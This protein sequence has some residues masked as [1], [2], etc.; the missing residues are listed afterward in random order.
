MLH[1]IVVVQLR[2]AD[3]PN[4][5]TLVQPSPTL[6][7]VAICARTTRLGPII[8]ASPT[9][10]ARCRFSTPGRDR[11]FTSLNVE[12]GAVSCCSTSWCNAPESPAY[13]D[14]SGAPPITCLAPL[15]PRR[16]KLH[17][18][19]LLSLGDL[20]DL[21]RGLPRLYSFV[22]IDPVAISSVAVVVCSRRGVTAER[23]VL[24]CRRLQS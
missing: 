15:P 13:V 23:G 22:C 14:A 24:T 16:C 1:A 3:P 7:R 20:T 11:Y 12:P 21:N 17:L 5:T 8:P 9:T 6:T 4:A 18:K 2:M 10:A 19:A